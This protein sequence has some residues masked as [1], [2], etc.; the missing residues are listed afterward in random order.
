MVAFA[1]LLVVASD[2]AKHSDSS[3]DCTMDEKLISKNTVY[4]LIEECIGTFEAATQDIYDRFGFSL[5]S[6]HLISS[7]AIGSLLGPK[8]HS[9][10]MTLQEHKI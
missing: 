2:L 3:T 10:T 4:E 9:V 6:S 1:N 5:S 7:D 8:G